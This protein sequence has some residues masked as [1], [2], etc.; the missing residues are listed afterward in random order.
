[1]DVFPGEVEKSGKP[2][3]EKF[4]PLIQLGDQSGVDEERDDEGGEGDKGQPED[5]A[6]QG[7]CPL[8]AEAKSAAHGAAARRLQRTASLPQ[9]HLAQP[10]LLSR[11]TLRMQIIKVRKGQTLTLGF[12]SCFISVHTPHSVDEL[13]TKVALCYV[14]P[15]APSN[16]E[17]RSERVECVG[18][19]QLALLI[20]LAYARTGNDLSRPCAAPA[21]CSSPPCPLPP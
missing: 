19:W 4:L 14:M 21:L 1:M 18:T 11:S 3:G 9:F 15:S 8:A 7:L 5:E 6:C 16:F 17:V 13:V 2:P 12:S 10:H 20:A